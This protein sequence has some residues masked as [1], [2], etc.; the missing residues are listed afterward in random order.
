[1]RQAAS[2]RRHTYG[3]NH[4]AI[5]RGEVGSLSRRLRLSKAHEG[6]AS[7]WKLMFGKANR[8]AKSA[9]RS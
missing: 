2:T 1:M 3:G 8:R 9:G 5:W 4:G 6:L 7:G